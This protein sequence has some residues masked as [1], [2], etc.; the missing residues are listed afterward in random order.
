MEFNFD[1]MVARQRLLE[2]MMEALESEDRFKVDEALVAANRF[3]KV[4]NSYVPD[5]PVENA[6]D[7]LRA[8]H[9]L[10]GLDAE[11]GNFT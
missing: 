10:D 3:L 9:P 5:A 1:R 11:E 4:G 6:R 7:K 8:A 2:Q